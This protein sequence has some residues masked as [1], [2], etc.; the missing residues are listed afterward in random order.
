MQNDETQINLLWHHT[1][2]PPFN[3]PIIVS[4]NHGLNLYF[5]FCDIA[6][7]ILF[8]NKE[9]MQRFAGFRQPFRFDKNVCRRNHCTKSSLQMAIKATKS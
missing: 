9:W 1:Y 3:L 5:I 7:V 8:K 4:F 6:T 2:H